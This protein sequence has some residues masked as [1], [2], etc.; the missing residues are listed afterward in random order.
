VGST[1]WWCNKKPVECEWENGVGAAFTRALS[2][3][4]MEGDL[5]GAYSRSDLKNQR[6]FVKTFTH[7]SPI[8][9][10]YVVPTHQ[11]Q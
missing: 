10:V 9:D 1:S 11:H 4:R 6:S 5:E 2:D 7:R 8:G 3:M